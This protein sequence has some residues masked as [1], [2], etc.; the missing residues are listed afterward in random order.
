VLD[1]ERGDNRV[2]TEGGPSRA[3]GR[4][5]LTPEMSARVFAGASLEVIAEFVVFEYSNGDPD[6]PERGD[7]RVLWHDTIRCRYPGGD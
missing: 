5:I 7:F 1:G 6:V 2:A 4:V 3:S